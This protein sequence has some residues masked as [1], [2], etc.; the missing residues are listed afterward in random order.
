M[1][2]V[3]GIASYCGALS[4]IRCFGISR[5]ILSAYGI[6]CKKIEELL[7]EK[8]SAEDEYVELIGGSRNVLDPTKNVTVFAKQIP[9]V[10]VLDTE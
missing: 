7:I 1:K 8:A 10:S 3:F 9:F 2:L 4:G 6:T 5:N